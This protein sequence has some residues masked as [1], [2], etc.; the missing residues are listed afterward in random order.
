MK[1]TDA[2]SFSQAKLQQ[3][4]HFWMTPAPSSYT[5]GNEGRRYQ[6]KQQGPS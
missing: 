4:V 1:R 3:E 5:F 6:V 2:I